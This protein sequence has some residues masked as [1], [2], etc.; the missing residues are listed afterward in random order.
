MCVHEYVCVPVCVR[1]CVCGY[2]CACVGV[3]VCVSVCV[4][5]CHN[6]IDLNSNYLQKAF[7]SVYKKHRQSICKMAGNVFILYN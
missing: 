7:L 5:A 2:V 3:C 1:V 6:L 4:C